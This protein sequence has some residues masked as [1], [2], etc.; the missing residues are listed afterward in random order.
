MAEC[1][2]AHHHMFDGQMTLYVYIADASPV[3]NDSDAHMMPHIVIC[4]RCD[5][6][7]HIVYTFWI[8]GVVLISQMY[9]L[10]VGAAIA[11]PCVV[12]YI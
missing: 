1:I 12:W 11:V 9:L 3:N 7:L 6:T 4:G 8:R 5:G 2:D 10:C